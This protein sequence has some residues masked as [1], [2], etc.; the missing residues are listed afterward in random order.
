MKFFFAANTAWEKKTRTNRKWRKNCI[1]LKVI[2]GYGKFGSNLSFWSYTDGEKIPDKMEPMPR[3]G[4]RPWEMHRKTKQRTKNH[5]ETRQVPLTFYESE[6]INVERMLRN[7]SSHV[8]SKSCGIYFLFE[9]LLPT[10]SARK[11]KYNI[12]KYP[13]I[14]YV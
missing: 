1:Y 14:K 13:S 5:W 9:N 8:E 6:M 2:Y 11:N 3:T 12:R 7:I 4:Q 10:N